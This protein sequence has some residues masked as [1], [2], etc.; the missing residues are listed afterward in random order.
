MRVTI[1]LILI[2]IAVFIAQ[3]I[4]P[5]LTNIFALTPAL[6]LHGAYWQFFTYMFLHGG[7]FHIALNML[8]FFMFGLAVER[9]LGEIRYITLY[10]LAGIGSAFLYMFLTMEPLV[11]MLGASGAIFGVLTA[12]GFLFPKNIVFLYFFPMPAWFAVIFFA[13]FE[14]FLGLTGIEPGIANFG[15]LGGI[16]TSAILMLYWRQRKRSQRAPELRGYE[17][18][19]E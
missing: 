12:Y 9:E 3:S 6:A 7:F 15:H 1:S 14:L 10:I 13:G 17:F 11:L 8:I 5:D 19:W 18:T 2:N 16:A 4:F